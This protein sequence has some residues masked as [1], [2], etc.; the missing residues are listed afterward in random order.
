[1]PPVLPWGCDLA[2]WS[3]RRHRLPACG[4]DASKVEM[5][6]V[7]LCLARRAG[8]P[9]RE[10]LDPHWLT[11]ASLA[12]STPGSYGKGAARESSEPSFTSILFRK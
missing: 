8:P 12:Y 3:V 4:G 6:R 9:D 1:M 10:R 2:V 11:S 5:F 7:R